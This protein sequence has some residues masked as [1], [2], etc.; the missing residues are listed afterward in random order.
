MTA[1]ET[2][3][4]KEFHIAVVDDDPDARD[5]LGEYLEHYGYKVSSLESGRALKSLMARDEPDLIILDLV[6]P[7]ENGITI[8]R[9]L[10]ETSQVGIIMLTGAGDEFD[11]IVGLEIGADDYLT[12]PC[13]MRE[14]LARVRAI[15][16]RSSAREQPPQE[17]GEQGFLFE[18]WKIHLAARQI[19]NPEGDAVSF[20]TAEYDLLVALLRNV[21]RV[22]SR[23]QLLT[24][25]KNREAGPF[26]RSI[27]NLVSRI[28]RKI[29]VDPSAPRIVK[30]VQSVG[31]VCAVEV[32]P[33]K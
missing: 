17:N 22:L 5:E 3:P 16:R 6:M 33:I 28:R 31:Y 19:T 4:P 7:G 2:A 12:K 15:L 23:D 9:E 27:D 30:T 11:E 18:G 8:T 21:N 13:N 24:M 1:S 32:K 20:T 26:D 25:T 14:L 29:E 10:R